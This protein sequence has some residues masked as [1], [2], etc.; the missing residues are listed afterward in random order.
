MPSPAQFPTPGPRV[1]LRF[2]LPKAGMIYPP[3]GSLM[4]QFRKEA[5]VIAG[6]KKA[7]PKL[8]TDA[9]D[10]CFSQIFREAA[11]VLG[12]NP[13]NSFASEPIEFVK[14]VQ[15]QPALQVWVGDMS[16]DYFVLLFVALCGARV[17]WYQ[18]RRPPFDVEE[19]CRVAR[20]I[21]EFHEISDLNCC[22]NHA[23]IPLPFFPSS[24]YGRLTTGP[25]VA[26]WLLRVGVL[27]RAARE[28]YETESLDGKED[29]EEEARAEN[30]DEDEDGLF[31]KQTGPTPK[32][33]IKAKQ[34][35]REGDAEQLQ[36]AADEARRQ[37]CL[38]IDMETMLQAFEKLRVEDAARCP[39]R[40]RRRNRIRFLDDSEEEEEE[41]GDVEMATG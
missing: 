4:R 41:E 7:L 10:T 38:T 5:A 40:A 16:P 18:N 27:G 15:R 19:H 3:D 2:F 12:E 9:V 17:K 23:L 21:D 29:S 14:W 24:T 25:A 22:V 6:L 33:R 28:L 35:E 34:Q 32:L 36:R 39:L 37:Y 26:Y 31:V 1:R 11:K 30:E 20:A 8:S 13:S